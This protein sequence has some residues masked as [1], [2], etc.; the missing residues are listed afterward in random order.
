MAIVR[1]IQRKKGLVLVEWQNDTGMIFRSWLIPDIIDNVGSELQVTD[2]HVGI[3]Y[4]E[5]FSKYLQYP[6]DVAQDIEQELKKLGIWTWAD[7]LSNVQLVRQ[8]YQN[9]LGIRIAPLL[10]IAA[11]EQKRQ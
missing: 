6:D 9:V 5:S 1:E 8:A 7:L 10:A 11:K 2:P 4:G 3:P